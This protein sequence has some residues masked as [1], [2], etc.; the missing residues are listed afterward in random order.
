MPR[1]GFP[2]PIRVG[3]ENHFIGF[4]RG[5]LE[6][7]DNRFLCGCDDKIRHKTVFDI[8]AEASLAFGGKV[9]DVTLA[10]HDFIIGA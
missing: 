7:A 1:D 4:L 8:D 5:G 10:G 6:F 2:F 9:T 3:R